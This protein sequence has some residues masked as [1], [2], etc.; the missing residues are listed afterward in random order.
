MTAELAELA[1]ALGDVPDGPFLVAIGGGADSAVAAALVREVA[2]EASVRLIHLDHRTPA[3]DDL[4]AVAGRL[5]AALEL[6]LEL[7]TL[8]V[9]AAGSWETAAREARRRA[10]REAAFGGEIIVTGHHRDDVAETVVAHM[11]RGSG[12]RG[13]SSLRAR[14]GGYWRPLLEVS[15]S[16]IRAIADELG[17]P[18]VDDPSNADTR[19]RR[20]LIRHEIL[21]AMTVL[22]PQLGASLA[23]AAA[24]LG[25]DDAELEAAAAEVPIRCDREAWVAPL[26]VL[27]VVSPPVRARALARLVRLARPPYGASTAEVARIAEVVSGEVRRTELADGLVCEV[28]GP[29]LALYRSADVPAPPDQVALPVPGSARFGDTTITAGLAVAPRQRADTVALD[30][31]EVGTDLVVR[32]TEHGERLAVRN[33]SKL[34]RDA[35]SEGGVPVRKR[36]G[37]PVVAAHGKIAWI[38]GV[39]VADWARARPTTERHLVLST[40]G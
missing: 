4:A 31:V 35:L 7:R 18:Y 20:N 23:R 22:N 2:G 9:P 1:A 36:A 16:R 26:P 37:W 5:A 11:A 25:E 24:H 14:G 29:L 17:L 21:P 8:D 30:A 33:G 40:G 34:V 13:L 3:S 32:A 38:V 12:A 28:E 6:P 27:A 10:L 19:H 39:R 15:R